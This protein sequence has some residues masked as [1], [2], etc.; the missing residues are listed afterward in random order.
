MTYYSK[1]YHF[2][3][4]LLSQDT[5]A[6]LRHWSCG[7]ISILWDI[8]QSWETPTHVE[9]HQQWPSIVWYTYFKTLLL[10]Q[11]IQYINI[12]WYTHHSCAIPTYVI[13]HQPMLCETP[14][15]VIE[16][17]PMLEDNLPMLEG[18]Y[19]CW[20]AT[21]HVGGQPTHDQGHLPVLEDN[22]PMFEGNYRFWRT[23]YLD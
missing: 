6:I 13:R 2:H 15:H 12:F 1:K 5:Q 17:L 14:T 9:G 8:H 11:Y 19:T 21:T 7:T 16:Q 22:L 10:T 23:T 3:N 18:N 4:T 20:R